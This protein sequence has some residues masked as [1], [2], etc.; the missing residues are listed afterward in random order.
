[1]TSSS[2]TSS[3]ISAPAGSLAEFY[4]RVRAF[5]LELCSTLGPE[6]MTV[7]SMPDVSPA[8]WHLAHVTWFFEHFILKNRVEGY[9]PIDERYHHLFN[10]YYYTAGDMYLRPRRGLISRPTV[11]DII[12]YRKHVDAHMSRLVEEADE[13]LAFLVTLGLNHE[14]QHQELILTDIK[15]VLAQNPLYPV[16]REDAGIPSGAACG[17]Q[18]WQEF[19]GGVTEIGHDG[20]SFCYDNETSRHRTWIE[21][22]EIAE[23]PV[24]NGEYL[25]FIRDGGYRKPELW[26]SD[27]WAT[28]Q[29]EG[30]TTPLY[31]LDEEHYFT[32]GGRQPIDMDA[33]V[34]HVSFYEADAFARWARAR[35]PT[36]AEW[37]SAARDQP[38]SGN[39]VDSGALH[40]SGGSGTK[41][42]QMFGD[43]WEWTASP[44]APYPGFRP[45]DGSLG[46]YNG[47]FMCSQ[48]VLRGGSCATP[49]DHVRATYRNFFYPQQRW[50]F[51]GIRLARNI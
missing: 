37:E 27:G 7:Q 36:E 16:F 26:L 4:R 33:P 34:T 2:A 11:E 25:E 14:Q 30:W 17:P 21:D 45:L 39:F 46:E 50:Q 44:Y 18:G 42:R 5:S 29:S 12:T 22:F 9:R 23:R 20:D 49:P 48:M 32:L 10:S 47:K 51:T 40:P 41:L 38:V 28:V 15:H 24:T 31:W 3:P 8:K 43:V 1:M 13:R 35:L 6:D 19:P